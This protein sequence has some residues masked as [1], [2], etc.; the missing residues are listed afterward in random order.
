MI[1][2]VGRD[3]Q[4]LSFIRALCCCPLVQVAWGDATYGAVRTG[5]GQVRR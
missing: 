5:S 3:Q 4:D 2:A 1:C